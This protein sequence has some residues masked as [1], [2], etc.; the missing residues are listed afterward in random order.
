MTES[1]A[2]RLERLG[3]EGLSFF[4]LGDVARAIACWEEM[5]RIDPHHAGALDYLETARADG[6]EE[7]R[8]VE[9]EPPQAAEPAGDEGDLASAD[10][11]AQGAPAGQG[12]DSVQALIRDAQELLHS[13]ELEG[14]LDLF[15]MAADLDPQRIEVDGYV[16][17]IRSRLLQRYRERIGD[18]RVVPKLLIAPDEIHRYNLPANAGFVLSLLDGATT[19]EQLISLSGMDSFE[20]LRI[21]NRLLDAEIAGI[22]R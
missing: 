16:D 21:V 14:A 18:L 17:M 12:A 3:R 11:A 8:V 20:A 19:V 9:P 13:Q 22:D 6:A 15:E 5:L 2:E 4:G 1:D 7:G 10:A